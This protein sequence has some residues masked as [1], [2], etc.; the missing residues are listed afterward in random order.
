LRR[1]NLLSSLSSRSRSLPD[2]SKPNLRLRN[3]YGSI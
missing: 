3:F 1:S 2:S